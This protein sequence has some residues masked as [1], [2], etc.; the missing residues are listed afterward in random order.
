M[1]AEITIPTSWKDVTLNEFI[2]LSC[3]DITTYK[4]P[5]EYYIHVLRIFGNKDLGNIFE[6][7]KASDINDIINQLSFM[8]EEPSKLDNKIVKIKGVEYHLIDNMN[9]ITIGEYVTIES[10]IEQDKLNS[11]EA[12]P[13]ILSVILRPLKE[14]FDSNKCKERIELFKNELSIE[15]VLG[16]SVFFSSGERL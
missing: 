16:M 9:D 1:K 13:V 4:T 7:I 8:N 14:V 2:K 11:V 3:L 10:L 6:F 12:I 15:D 5:L